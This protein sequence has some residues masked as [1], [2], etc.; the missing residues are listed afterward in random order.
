MDLG[1][2]SILT[3]VCP[4]LDLDSPFYTVIL[5]NYCKLNNM[6]LLKNCQISTLNLSYCHNL[7]NHK[8]MIMYLFNKILLVN[9]DELNDIS[10]FTNGQSC[11]VNLFAYVDFSNILILSNCQIHTL[12]LSNV[13]L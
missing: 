1:G 5:H 11:T 12:I 6:S 8:E 9:C 3:K 2:C 4:Y 13:F 7:I 10:P